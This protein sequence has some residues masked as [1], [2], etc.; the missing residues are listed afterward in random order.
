[1]T[2]TKK[3]IE[4]VKNSTLAIDIETSSKLD[5]FCKK[6]EITKKDFI[7]LSL[8]YFNRTGIDP[9]SNDVENNLQSWKIY[10]NCKSM[11]PSN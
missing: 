1:M 11:Q 4:K 3:R 8:D 5:I 6:H 2:N 10:L 9:Q 7:S